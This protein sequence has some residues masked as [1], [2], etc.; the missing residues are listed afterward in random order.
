M[1]PHYH[2]QLAG[3]EIALAA[4]PADMLRVLRAVVLDQIFR[5]TPTP[6]PRSDPDGRTGPHGELS[7][8]VVRALAA[9]FPMKNI[10]GA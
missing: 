10:Y 7:P 9:A 8:I 3:V 5:S 1:C 2:A 4:A 6:S